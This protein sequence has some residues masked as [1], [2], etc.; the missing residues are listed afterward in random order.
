M[1]QSFSV[2]WDTTK[3]GKISSNSRNTKWLFWCDGSNVRTFNTAIIARERCVGRRYGR[4]L[5]LFVLTYDSCDDTRTHVR[6]SKRGSKHWSKAKGKIILFWIKL[7]ISN[8]FLYRIDIHVKEWMNWHS[9]DCY[10]KLF[11]CVAVVFCQYK[12]KILQWMFID[13]YRS[14]ICIIV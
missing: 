13:N 1:F 14:N 11:V 8:S 5:A 9:I 12:M 3:I 7:C 10:H 4:C 6:S 2:Q